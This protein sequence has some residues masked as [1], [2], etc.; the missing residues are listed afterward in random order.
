M[1]AIEQLDYVKKYFEPLRGKTV[2][3]VDFY[4]QVLFPASSL[5][6]EHIVFASSIDKLTTRA[7]E[8]EK[9][10]QLR[11]NAYKQNK[12][13]D[14][15]SDG[16]IWKSEI[17]TKVQIY[18]AEGLS[19]KATEFNCD[20]EN[21]TV[22][23]IAEQTKWHHPI[24]HPQL[25]GWYNIWAPERSIHSNNISGRTKGKHDG[26]D[27]YAPVGT[28]VYACV[29]GEI[30]EI[31]V[32]ESYGNCINIKG[33]YNGKIYW[34]FYAHLS[35]ISIKAKDSFGKATKVKAGEPI[36]KSG[37]TGSSAKALHSKQIHLHF[38]VRT[39]KERTGGRVDPF[40]HINEL[41]REV[42]R[43][44]KKEDQP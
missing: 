9:L 19:N 30:N 35:N 42:I 10:K 18:I 41:N 27:L 8:S 36:G 44:P 11:I 24:N 34:F 5:K 17:K 43:N 4:L 23:T 21:T 2:E 12:G 13:L 26:I 25:R 6:E 3:F 1:T 31:Y 40:S 14:I 37:K 20:D 32:S 33:E 39:T 7:T 15:N 28:Q 29:D 16:I 38:E 22:K